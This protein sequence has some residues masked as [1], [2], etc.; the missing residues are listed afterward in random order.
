MII[1]KMFRINS[2]VVKITIHIH[3]SFSSSSYIH[4]SSFS[5]CSNTSS[6]SYDHNIQ[7]TF[8]SFSFSSY[9]RTSLFPGHYWWRQHLSS[10]QLLPRDTSRCMRI[11]ICKSKSQS[12]CP[13]SFI[14][15][16]ED[17]ILSHFVTCWLELPF[18]SSVWF[19]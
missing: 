18:S 8:W 15:G 16:D 2:D 12:E 14:K 3:T 9:F 7:M 4:I 13:S 10:F 1:N 5:F 19:E 11:E 17:D 6:S